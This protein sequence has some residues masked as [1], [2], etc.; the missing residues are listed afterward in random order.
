M[1]IALRDYDRS[2]ECNIYVYD[3]WQAEYLR[4][5][6]GGCK[7]Y[8]HVKGVAEIKTKAGGRPITGKAKSAGERMKEMRARR[9]PVDNPY[10][11]RLRGKSRL[12]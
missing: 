5:R 12:D 10:L 6:F 4:D 11:A 8:T 1:R 9:K 3:E 7:G 2:D